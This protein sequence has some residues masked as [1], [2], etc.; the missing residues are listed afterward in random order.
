M[1]NEIA[2]NSK[3]EWL[4]LRKQ[5]GV[6]GS[7][8][9]AVIGLNPYKSAYAL[10]AE[11][12]GRIP[13]FEGN[14]TTEV[15]SYLEEFVAKLFERETGKKVRRKNKM[16]VNTDYPWAF[17]DVDRLVVGEKAL[18][19]IKTTNSFPIMKQARNGEFPEQYYAQ[20]VHYLAVSGLDK[21]YLA[22]LIGCRD[23]KIFELERDEGEIN[24]LMCAE[25]EFWL[26]YVKTNTPPPADGAVSTSETLSTIYP[27]SNG[28]TVNLMAYENDLKQYM[29]FTTL[30]KDVEKQ[31]DEVANRIKAFMGESGRGITNHFNVSWASSKRVS[32]DSKKFASDHADM[33]L[34]DYYKTTNVRTFKVSENSK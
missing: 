34:S 26:G 1:V 25:E 21:A 5:L 28:D 4:S 3:E 13:E 19:E 16:L 6:G 9:G 14:L 11:K 12:T 27:E 32:F 10:W 22:I 31:R 17:A 30:I 20:V 29:T 7:D 8:A 33:D 24:A 23:F 18:L 2:Y 15:G